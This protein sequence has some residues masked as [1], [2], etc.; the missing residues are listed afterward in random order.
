MPHLVDVVKGGA[1]IGPVAVALLF[2]ILHQGCHHHDHRASIL[3]H[4]LH[5]SPQHF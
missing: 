5:H 2:S 4:H 1:F 3:P